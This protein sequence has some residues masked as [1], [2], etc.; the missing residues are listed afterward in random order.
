[1]GT[2]VQLKNQINDSYFQLKDSVRVNLSLL[3]KKLKQNLV[4]KVGLVKKWTINLFELEEKDCELYLPWDQ[5][6]YV[7]ILKVQEM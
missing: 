5:Q 4:G 6:N 3:E 1:M 7:D 2:V